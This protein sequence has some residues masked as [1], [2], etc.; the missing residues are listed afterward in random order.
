MQGKAS[1]QRDGMTP[2]S[3]SSRVGGRVPLVFLLFICNIENMLSKSCIGHKEIS[4]L[5]WYQQ[6]RFISI[7][8]YVQSVASSS[9]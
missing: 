4:A 7:S 1:H 6:G 5:P 2:L 9:T 3:V 8:F